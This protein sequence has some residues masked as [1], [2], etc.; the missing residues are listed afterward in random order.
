MDPM[1]RR[2]E[3]QWLLYVA[4]NGPPTSAVPA[5]SRES[6]KNNA[7]KLTPKGREEIVSAALKVAA[8]QEAHS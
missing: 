3:L 8:S 7:E 4:R 6:N 2:A 1:Q 5:D